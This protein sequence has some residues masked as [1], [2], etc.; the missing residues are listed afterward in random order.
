MCG[1]FAQSKMEDALVE[2]YGITGAVP[3]SPLP[4]S[5]NIAPTKEIYI[6]R[7]E[8]SHDRELGVASWGL[9]GSWY[10]DVASA[11]ASQSHAINARRESIFEKPTFRDAV[12]KRRCLVPADGYFEWA[13]ALGP[14]R[15][16]QPFYISSPNN[17]PLSFAGIWNEWISPNGQLIESVAIVTCDSVGQLATIHSRMPVILPRDRW[18]S[19]LDPSSQDPENVRKLMEYS[20]LYGGLSVSAVSNFVNSV[21]HN[22]PELIRPI[23]LGEPQT[24]F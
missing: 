18:E 16:K 23:T 8:N 10:K 3:T 11:R 2:E 15:P 9:I 24:L 12:R 17:H 4:A 14:Y 1:R 19:W 21:A 6:V 5:W 7:N 22:G 13:T 20:D